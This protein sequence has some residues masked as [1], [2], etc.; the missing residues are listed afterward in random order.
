M[1]IRALKNS[2]EK[3]IV[4]FNKKFLS[5]T[6]IPF[7]IP[8]KPNIYPLNRKCI[9]IELDTSNPPKIAYV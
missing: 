8:E 4:S 3:I 7:D 1:K 5:F 6:I 2:Y 9:V